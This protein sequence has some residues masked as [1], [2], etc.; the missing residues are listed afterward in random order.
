MEQNVWQKRFERE[1]AARK[2]AERLLEVKSLALYEANLLLEEKVKERTQR[3]EEALE[4]A[5]VAQ[6]AKAAFFATMSHELRTPLNSIIGFS[7]ILVRQGDFSAKARDYLE[8]IHISGNTLLRLI[9]TLL[10]FA[11]LESQQMRLHPERIYLRSLLQEQLDLI[12]KPMR[13]KSLILSVDLQEAELFADVT[14][15]GQ[16]LHSILSNALKFTPKGGSVKVSSFAQEKQFYIEICDSGMGIPA[17]EME[18]LF[19]PFSKIEN[20]SRAAV[21]GSGLGLYITK[22]ILHLHGG[23]ISVQSKEGEGSC[24]RLSLPTWSCDVTKKDD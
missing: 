21:D 6:K 14:L 2:E 10:N 4:E 15:L 18:H 8:K 17:G 13:E 22:K 9:N 1:R 16:A 24:F 19:K 11:T 7:Q 5:K 12:E 23:E 20:S 3:L